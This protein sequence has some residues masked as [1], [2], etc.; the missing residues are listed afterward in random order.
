MKSRRLEALVVVLVA[1]A[2]V[3]LSSSDAV[4]QEADVDV[5]ELQ[6]QLQQMYLDRLAVNDAA[7]WASHDEDD[8]Q[9][10]DHAGCPAGTQYWRRDRVTEL[11]ATLCA[12]DL[13][14]GP[15]DG[16]CRILDVGDRGRSPEVPFVDDLPPDEIDAWMEGQD[17]LVTPVMLCDP[18][19]EIEGATDA[20]LPNAVEFEADE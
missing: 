17:P 19:W 20:E 3:Q 6:L 1:A 7:A 16:R 12:S 11:C 5:A 14:C 2:V 9:H 13:D 4:G 18:F 8:N 10:A 15:E